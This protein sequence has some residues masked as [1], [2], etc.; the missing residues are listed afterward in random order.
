MYSVVRNGEGNSSHREVKQG[1]RQVGSARP[2]RPPELAKPATNRSEPGPKRSS[3]IAL[4]ECSIAIDPVKDIGVAFTFDD[5]KPDGDIVDEDRMPGKPS[6]P[7]GSVFG[8]HSHFMILSFGSLLKRTGTPMSGSSRS[9]LSFSFR[10][11]RYCAANSE[12][13]RARRRGLGHHNRKVERAPRLLRGGSSREGAFTFAASAHSHHH[14]MVKEAS[15]AEVERAARLNIDTIVRY[16][17][18]ARC[19]WSASSRRR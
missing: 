15:S 4:V 8:S 1:C 9:S 17:S 16:E 7:G 19:S 13:P 11:L 12:A 18:L 2:S 6:L 5:F 10:P 3:A 14:S